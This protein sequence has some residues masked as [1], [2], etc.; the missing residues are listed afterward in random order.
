MMYGYKYALKD[1]LNLSPTQLSYC[2][3]AI[4]LPLFLSFFLGLLRDRWR[5]FGIVDRPYLLLSPL[6]VCICCLVIGIM[7]RSLSTLIGSL[8]AI[9]ASAMLSG[10]SMSGMLAL[11]SKHFGLSG[12]I[13]V[14]GMVIPSLVGIAL[15]SLTGHLVEAAGFSSI[16]YVSAVL[17]LPV[18]ILAFYR[19][20]ELFPDSVAPISSF[21]L[22][23]QN[24]SLGAAVKRLLASRPAIVAAL[25][26][27]LWDFTPGWGTPLFYQYTNVLHFSPAQFESTY[28]IGTVGST[29]SALS[30]A[31][32]CFRFSTKT[33]LVFGIIVCVAGSASLVFVSSYH[34]ALVV[35][36]LI[37]LT[38]GLA[39]AG[40]YDLLYR[41]SPPGL[42]GV[43]VLLGIAA[44]YVAGTVADVFGSF[45]YEH[46]GFHL[47]LYTT[48]AATA[49]ILPLVYLV[50]R[51]VIATREGNPID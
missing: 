50:P 26:C 5:P 20:A 16:C 23:L 42:E 6:I 19:P 47:A 21:Q 18:A 38:Y 30:Y 43:A 14:A 27:F 17:A 49:L 15:M 37:G 35:S 13:S 31:F 24:E 3:F 44:T 22:G 51:N 46:G 2:N 12:R 40:V 1:E 4:N 9:N 10:A 45:L 41:A 34:S 11:L 8:V 36:L 33:L 25:I 39:E 48:L 7:H 29:L 28:T 32:F